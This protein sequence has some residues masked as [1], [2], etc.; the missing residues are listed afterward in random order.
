MQTG[1]ANCLT[2]P[3]WQRS[4]PAF[5]QPAVLPAAQ[6]WPLSPAPMQPTVQASPLPP[7]LGMG[8][9]QLGRPYHTPLRPNVSRRPQFMPQPTS[10]DNRS[11]LATR[12]PGGGA[13]REP[14]STRAATPFDPV[15]VAL[16]AQQLPSLPPFS[17]D[18]VSDDGESFAE[19][20]ERLELVATTCRWDDQ[21]KLVNVATR[22]RGAA[23]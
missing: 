13:A 5:Q 19:L 15:S 2:N 21:A 20:L 8:P 7:Q 9:T 1:G 17:G 6:L 4:K 12:S 22:L 3:D 16:L 18:N 23:S 11:L 10:V 14:V